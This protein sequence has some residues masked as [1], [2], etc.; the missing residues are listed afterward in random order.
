MQGDPKGDEAALRFL[1]ALIVEAIKSKTTPPT[2]FPLA[3]AEELLHSEYAKGPSSGSIHVRTADSAHSLVVAPWED[4]AVVDTKGRLEKV[5][6]AAEALEL[7]SAR[8]WV[9]GGET[10]GRLVRYSMLLSQQFP[11]YRLHLC[12]NRETSCRVL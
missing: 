9:V 6:T 7:A 10:A 12:F 4:S 1:I 2:N 5:L 8:C 3:D 11:A